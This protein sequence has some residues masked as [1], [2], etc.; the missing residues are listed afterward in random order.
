ML[1]SIR[2]EP[3]VTQSLK[4]GAQVYP[5]V[6]NAFEALCWILAHQDIA[7]PSIPTA[8]QV[9]RLH[10]QAAGGY[11]VPSLTVIYTLDAKAITLHALKVG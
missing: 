9:Y 10:K 8:R 1:F 7:G 2:E 4:K 6:W 3:A 5:R 11:G